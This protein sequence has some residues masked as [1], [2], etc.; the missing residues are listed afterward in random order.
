VS[1][2]PRRLFFHHKAS[3]VLP[4]TE[5]P[6]PCKSGSAG[7]DSSSAESPSRREYTA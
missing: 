1:L 4:A 6:S 5:S 7:N 3:G 2:R